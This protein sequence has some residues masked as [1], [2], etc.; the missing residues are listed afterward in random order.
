MRLNTNDSGDSLT[1]NGVVG[2]KSMFGVDRGDTLRFSV[3]AYYEFAP[4]DDGFFSSADLLLAILAGSEGGTG[5]SEGISLQN[6]S[7]S[8]SDIYN[9]QLTKNGTVDDDV[10]RAYLNYMFF[11]EDMTY[12]TSGFTQIT[13]A[14]H[15]S[16]EAVAFDEP[17]VI[18]ENGF[19][20]VYVSNETNAASIVDFDNLTITHSKTPII[21]AS[22]FEPFGLEFATFNRSYSQKVRYKFQ[23]QEYDETPGWYAYKYRNHDPVLGRFFNIDPLAEK[24]LYNSTYAFSENK[25]VAHRELEGLEAYTIKLNA[26]AANKSARTSFGNRSSTQITFDVLGNVK[27]SG[28]KIKILSASKVPQDDG[29]TIISGHFKGTAGKGKN[30][31]EFDVEVKIIALP[32]A[33]LDENSDLTSG[34]IQVTAT[35]IPGSET[36]EANVTVNGEE[37]TTE[38]PLEVVSSTTDGKTASQTF[39]YVW[40]GHIGTT[41]PKPTEP[42]E[43]TTIVKKKNGN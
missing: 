24:Y 3:Q 37:D 21:Y 28:S 10:P 18:A 8:A 7:L 5:V 40:F 15:N 34:T 2:L 19:M 23:E 41:K 36:K 31:S 12:V 4:N 29:S 6:S 25:V 38:K 9:T 27:V 42:F 1:F 17:I 13:S 22:S 30:T 20:L 11:K 43:E 35:A 14:A 32:K 39:N 26:E 33:E 16:W